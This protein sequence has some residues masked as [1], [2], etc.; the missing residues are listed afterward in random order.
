[1]SIGSR[2]K[3]DRARPGPPSASRAADTRERLFLAGERLFAERGFDGVSVR[4]IVQEA[5][6]NLAA[7]SYHFGSK[8]DLFLEI[9]RRRTR[10]MNRDRLALLRDAEARAGAAPPLGDILRA[11]IGPP[12]LWRDPRSGRDGAARF[13]NRA[14][15]EATPELRLILETDVSHLR[16]F[17]PALA[18]ALPSRTEAE[19][20]W[21]LHFALGLLHQCTDTNHRRLGILSGGRCDTDDV[22]AVLDRIVAFAV[23]GI[24]AMESPAIPTAGGGNH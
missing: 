17:I 21:A 8:G 14:L 2:A 19:V 7:I 22:Q 4:D 15:A 1:M 24:A 10:E 11:L 6:A 3:A 9:F 23:A 20:C 18:R 5:G 16:H 13:V 12:M